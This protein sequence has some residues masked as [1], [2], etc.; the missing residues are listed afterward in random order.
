MMGEIINGMANTA[1][2]TLPI[3]GLMRLSRTAMPRPSERHNARDRIVNTMVLMPGE[4]DLS[5]NN[6]L[7]AHPDRGQQDERVEN[8][9]FGRRAR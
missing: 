3:D 8:R 9:A 7:Q 4:F 2:R 5:R 1:L 6:A